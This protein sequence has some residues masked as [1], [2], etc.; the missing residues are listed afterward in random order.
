MKKC[1]VCGNR[2]ERV[3]KTRHLGRACRPCTEDIYAR[4]GIDLVYDPVD[5]VFFEDTPVFREWLW[6]TR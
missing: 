4:M 1:R 2:V 5:D 6:I 3:Y